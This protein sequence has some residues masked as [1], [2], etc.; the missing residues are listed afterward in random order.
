MLS[1]NF[2]GFCNCN[3]P[4]HGNHLTVSASCAVRSFRFLTVIFWQKLLIFLILTDLSSNKIYEAHVQKLSI[5][6][7]KITE[8]NQV[9]K[10]TSTR[11]N[12]GILICWCF[13]F[14]W[15]DRICIQVRFNIIIMIKFFAF[16]ILAVLT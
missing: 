5:A 2:T 4:S 6:W 14:F 3:S 13:N 8:A 11:R 1:I 9:Q 7:R 16:W 10:K 15:N 12:A